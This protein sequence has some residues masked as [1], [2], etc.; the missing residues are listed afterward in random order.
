[1]HFYFSIQISKITPIRFSLEETKQYPM[2]MNNLIKVD[3]EKAGEE[4]DEKFLGK[5]GCLLYLTT[6][7]VGIC[8]RFK[9]YP[10]VSN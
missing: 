9:F 10:K 2:P 6:S 7:S 4:V 8:V 3:K 5:I 1:M